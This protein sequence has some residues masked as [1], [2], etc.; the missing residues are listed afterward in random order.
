MRLNSYPSHVH[1]WNKTTIQWCKCRVDEKEWESSLQ[2]LCRLWMGFFIT[3]C[4]STLVLKNFSHW[5]FPFPL[6]LQM[7]VFVHTFWLVSWDEAEEKL[8]ASS[9]NLGATS[10]QAY[11]NTGQAICHSSLCYY[12]HT[13][14]GFQH[15][16]N[17][18]K[19]LLTVNHNGVYKARG[20]WHNY[21]LV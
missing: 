7:V 13:H 1:F 19:I 10:P 3:C 4:E 6:L 2:T 17:I 20:S 16:G 9:K 8:L 21:L 18:A 14:Y 15:Y 11:I 5:L 12:E